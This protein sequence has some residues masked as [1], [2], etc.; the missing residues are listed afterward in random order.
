MPTDNV[1]IAGD[2]SVGIPIFR[3]GGSACSVV[4]LVNG[5][6]QSALLGVPGHHPRSE[7]AGPD[8]WV[9]LG[10]LARMLN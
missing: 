5:P 7:A 8:C 2:R 1:K 3:G 10:Q 6:R 9:I 4:P